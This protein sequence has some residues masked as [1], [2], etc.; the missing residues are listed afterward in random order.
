GSFG[1]FWVDKKSPV[2]NGPSI[3]PTSPTYGQSVT[4]NYSCTDGGSGVTLCGPSGSNTISPT[5][6]TG[7]L[8]SPADSSVGM[9]T[10]TVNAHDAVG[11]QSTPGS[12]TY[13]VGKA[14]TTTTITSTSPNP[15][16][17]NSP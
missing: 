6:N 10:F 8:S 17:V 2:I 1:P 7:P 3:S 4:A 15:A 13:T 9:H 14:T 11:N 12:I 5:G 16:V